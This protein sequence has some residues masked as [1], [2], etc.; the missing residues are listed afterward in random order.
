MALVAPW[1]M[2]TG[3]ITMAEGGL[4]RLM[5]YMSPAFPT[6]AFAYSSGLEWAMAEG[7][8]TQANI[9]EWLA[10]LLEYGA[11]WTDAVLLSLA[12]REGADLA[13]LDDTA[14]ALCLSSERLRET[15]DQGRAFAATV[16][17]ITGQ[18]QP[19]AALPVATARASAPLGLTAP[20]IIAAY[21]QTYVGNLVMAATR[22]LPMGQNQ[23]Q[24]LLAQLQP[25]IQRL[26]DQAAMADES[27][28]ITAAIG[29][30]FAALDH[31]TMQT[32]IFRT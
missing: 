16:A 11:G 22:F 27:A 26:A 25:L 23:G 2:I 9:A 29:A 6:G 30:E 1:G 5:Q 7:V 14:C 4:L 10:D 12:L 18:P 20:V 31:E 21:L 3:C 15:L 17:A 8:V 13:A 32:R 24:V 19:K 28:L